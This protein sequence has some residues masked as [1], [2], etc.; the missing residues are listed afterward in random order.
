[1][2]GWTIRPARR[3][4]AE[5]VGSISA[6]AYLP[7][8]LPIIGTAPQ[9]AF[10][11]Y[12]PWIERGAVWLLEAA[13]EIAGVMVLEPRPDHLLVYSVAVRPEHQRKGY[14]STLLTFAETL[15]VEAGLGELRLYTNR[16][17][18]DN[19]RLYR[20]CG[21]VET[22]ERPHPSRVGEVLVDLAKTLR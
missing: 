14:G 16:R 7:A 10:E 11:D 9:P 15:T 6:E 3:S 19:L 21:F 12:G 13:G 18:T 22:G 5:L 17:M 2:D 20:A 1:M 4:D 8:Y